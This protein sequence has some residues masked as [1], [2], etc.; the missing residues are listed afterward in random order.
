MF[1]ARE[2]RVSDFRTSQVNVGTSATPLRA[3]GAEDYHVVV[4]KNMGTADVFIGADDTVTTSTGFPVASGK[5]F[6]IFIPNGKQIYAVAG[7]AQNVAVIE[8]KLETY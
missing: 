3:S 2:Y 8:Y 6:E 5:T 1:D 4:V 7:A